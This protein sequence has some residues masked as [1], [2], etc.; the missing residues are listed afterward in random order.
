MR[1]ACNSTS[2]GASTT[3]RIDVEFAVV[4]RFNYEIVDSVVLFGPSV[5]S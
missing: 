2:S 1:I 3:K 5:G 4:A